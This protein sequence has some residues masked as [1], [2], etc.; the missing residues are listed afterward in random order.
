MNCLSNNNLQLL[1]G[2]A[3]SEFGSYAIVS[4]C[5]DNGQ[6]LQVNSSMDRRIVKLR[7]NTAWIQFFFFNFHTI[8]S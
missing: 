5:D 3:A 6:K 8:Y 7:W 1:I 4:V 2:A